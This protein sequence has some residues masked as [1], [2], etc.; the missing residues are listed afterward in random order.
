MINLINMKTTSLNLQFRLLIFSIV[1]FCTTPIQA[2]DSFDAGLQAYYPFSGNGVDAS[3]NNHHGNVSGAQLTTD[4]NNSVDSAYSFDGN[5]VIV[6]PEDSEVFN[7]Q[8]TG[9]SIGYWLKLDSSQ[10]TSSLPVVAGYGGWSVKGWD[11][12]VSGTNLVF[13]LRSDTDTSCSKYISLTDSQNQW[14]HFAATFS[15]TT[16]SIFKNGGLVGQVDCPEYYPTSGYDLTLGASSKFDNGY[17]GLVGQLDDVRI[18]N[19]AITQMEVAELSEDATAIEV[20]GKGTVFHSNFED[21]NLM[22]EQSGYALD[23]H[24]VADDAIRVVENPD[25]DSMNNSDLVMLASTVPSAEGEYTRAEYRTLWDEPFE[26]YQK[27]HTFQWMVYFPEGYMVDIDTL[28]GGG[29]W[30]LITQFVTH[31]CAW[32]SSVEG[33]TQFGDGRICG[34]GGIFNEIRINPDNHD[35]YVFEYRADPDCVK[36]SYQYPRGEWLKLTYEIFWTDD[37]SGFYGVWV[38]N[39]LVAQA[40]NV[41]TLPRGFVEGTCDIRWKVGLYDSWADSEV[42]SM[43]YYLDNLELYIDKDIS[44]VC[45]DCNTGFLGDIDGNKA[46]VPISSLLLLNN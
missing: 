38:N 8:E 5:D 6:V 28:W 22:P 3:G 39:Q 44:E 19:R 15:D 17:A 7:F 24:R 20:A 27:K 2:E 26:T 9:F 46:F 4:R 36:V 11:I 25:K 1:F 32:N 29:N 45:P 43:Y 18:Y 35:E 31:P 13:N 33:Y 14:L 34:S 37:S 12:V 23:L 30:N 16:L 42:G 10:Q 21:G 41:Q 40:D